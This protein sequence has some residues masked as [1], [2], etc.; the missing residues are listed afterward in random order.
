MI[1][2]SEFTK[3]V[4]FNMCYLALGQAFKII[5]GGPIVSQSCTGTRYIEACLILYTIFIWINNADGSNWTYV[6]F[7]FYKLCKYGH[8]STTMLGDPFNQK[9]PD[10]SDQYNESLYQA[11]QILISWKDQTHFVS[12]VNIRPK[13]VERMALS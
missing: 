4:K 7:Q 11:L 5:S 1:Q 13:R 12:W 6:L 2:V 9:Q 8:R 3:Q 10:I